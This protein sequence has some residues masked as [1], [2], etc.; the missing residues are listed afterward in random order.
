VDFVS[1]PL[2]QARAKAAA[3]NVSVDFIQGDVTQL[4]RCGIGAGAQLIVDND[5]LHNMSDAD[6]DAYVREVSAVAA[7]DAR[8]FIVAFRPGGRFGVRGVEPSEMETR[9]ASAWTLLAAGEDGDLD[10]ARLSW[11]RATQETP[12]WYYVYTHHAG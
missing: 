6:R 11:G 10:E 3:A 12:A 8:L 7:H 9:F 2:E 1:K 5:C 4:S